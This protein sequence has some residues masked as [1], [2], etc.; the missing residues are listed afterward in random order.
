ML[1]LFTASS[2]FGG[3]DAERQDVSPVRQTCPAKGSFDG[4]S[5]RFFDLG[6][7]TSFKKFKAFGPKPVIT[8]D[9]GGSVFNDYDIDMF[10]F[11]SKCTRIKGPAGATGTSTAGYGEKLNLGKAARFVIITYY[12]GHEMNMPITLEAS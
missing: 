8:Q 10:A 3:G 2:A 1:P 9:V 7:G 11:D 6:D 12:T 5:W 4:Y